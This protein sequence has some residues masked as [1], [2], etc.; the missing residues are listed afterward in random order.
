M[1]KRKCYT[2][3]NIFKYFSKKKTKIVS[4]VRKNHC[5]SV[6][7]ITESQRRDVKMFCSFLN[8]NVNGMFPTQSLIELS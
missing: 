5:Y 8:F 6:T 2:A 7:E 1:T 4:A 3:C